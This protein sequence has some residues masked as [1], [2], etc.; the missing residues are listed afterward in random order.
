M[1]IINLKSA[2]V[3]EIGTFSI[4]IG[5]FTGQDFRILGLKIFEYDDEFKDYLHIFSIQILKFCFEFGFSNY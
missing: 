1:N 2:I 3:F 5:W 4:S